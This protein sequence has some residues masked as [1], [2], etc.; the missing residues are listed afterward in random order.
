M[1]NTG[2]QQRETQGV[3]LAGG[4]GT[5]LYPSTSA[6]SKHLMPIYDK[7]MI[8]YSLST[9]M[10]ADIRDI[11]IICRR[12]DLESFKLLFSHLDQIGVDFS[13]LVQE[14]PL[15]IANGILIS[16]RLSGRTILCRYSWRTISFM[17]MILQN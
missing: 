1:F 14:Q 5:R 11:L 9:L 8:Y 17:A 2:F 6:V 13:F 16:Q 4:C 7:P 15:G 3:I 10:L 12:T